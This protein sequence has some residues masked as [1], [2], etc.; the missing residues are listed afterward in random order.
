[1]VSGDIWPMVTIKQFDWLFWS[2]W[3]WAKKIDDREECITCFRK[4]SKWLM[5][6]MK[7]KHY[8]LIMATCSTMVNGSSIHEWHWWMMMMMMM[9]EWPNWMQSTVAFHSY[10]CLLCVCMPTPII[11]QMVLC[12]LSYHLI[13]WMCVC[14]CFSIY[15]PS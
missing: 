3:L 9:I 7:K 11:M 15:G 2:K 1:M 8:E 12:L 5:D 13:V 4:Q 14:V 10:S 6:H